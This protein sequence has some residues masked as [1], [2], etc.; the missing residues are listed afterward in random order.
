MTFRIEKKWRWLV[1]AGAVFVPGIV[2]GAL[3]VPFTFKAGD[4]IR[5]ADVNANFAALQSR[6]D[7]LSATPSTSAVVGTLTVAGL[8]KA[9]PLHQF[10]MSVDVPVALVA[11]A[12]QSLGKPTLS[13]VSVVRDMDSAS[14][15]FDLQLNNEKVAATASITLGNVTVNLTNVTI[16]QVAVSGSGAQP[17]ETINLAYQKIEWAWQS[18]A[19]DM[20]VLDYDR[21]K[22]MAGSSATVLNLKLGYYA[23]GGTPDPTVTAITSFSHSMVVPTA[24][25]GS[26]SGAPKAQHGAFVVRKPVSSQ[27]LDELAVS[28][29]GLAGNTA[30]LQIYDASGAVSNEIK[31]AGVALQSLSLSADASGVSDAVS[32]DY[33]QIQ[34]LA[35]ANQAAW[36]VAKNAAN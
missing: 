3:S 13:D 2:S 22:A 21:S 35:G 4:P 32:L 36:D 16:T 29:T 11:G 1:A 14:P 31:L 27:T 23:S 18:T 34:W 12:G 30:D 28:L 25:A 8:A 9:V 6:L 20:K 24:T 33:T 15:L 10:S 19:D 17:Q 7:A 26:G 5:A